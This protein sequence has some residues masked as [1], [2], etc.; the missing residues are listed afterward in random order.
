V[1]NPSAS[2]I[3]SHFPDLHLKILSYLFLARNGKAASTP[4]NYGYLDAS[5][6]RETLGD[7]DRK[8]VGPKIKA[9]KLVNSI[10]I[11]IAR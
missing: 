5:V 8:K 1:A 4:S 6:S 7:E 10:N 2:L 9:K 3:I 11:S